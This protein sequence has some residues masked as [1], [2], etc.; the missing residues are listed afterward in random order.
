MEKYFRDEMHSGFV[1]NQSISMAFVRNDSIQN[2]SVGYRTNLFRVMN[3][4][5]KADV[6]LIDEKVADLNN[7][8]DAE[9]T[10]LNELVIK[11]RSVISKNVIDITSKTVY[12]D[13]NDNYTS[14]KLQIKAS[15]LEK[16]ALN[17]LIKDIDGL[18]KDEESFNV[19]RTNIINL[20]KG[21]KTKISISSFD[22]KT[23][24]EMNITKM[25]AFQK[26]VNNLSESKP[27][28]SIDFAGAYN[29]FFDKDRFSSGG[30]GRFGTW[31]TMNWNINLDSP[32]K[33]EQKNYLKLYILNRFLIDRMHYNKNANDYD[34]NSFM[35]LA[36]K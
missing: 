26:F 25:K 30:F 1:H 33:E 9:Y 21:L 14:I 35:I 20:Y 24:S 6:D 4:K 31:L 2:L 34:K 7:L 12:S 23:F 15:S 3:K 5:Y 22:R 32:D 27:I 11:E 29:H 8:N 10:K 16:E 18:A 36:V 17:D 28:F 19:N 13:F